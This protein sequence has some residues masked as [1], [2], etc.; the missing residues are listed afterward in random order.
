MPSLAWS[1]AAGIPASM[2]LGN[3]AAPLLYGVTP[4]D[5]A[6][7]ARAVMFVTCVAFAASYLPV[8]R[9]RQI[10]PLVALRHEQ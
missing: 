4:A 10:D 8:R 1:L 5:A 6:T 7:Q 2:L 9:A 3:A